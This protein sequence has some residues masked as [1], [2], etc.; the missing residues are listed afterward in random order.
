MYPP[1]DIYTQIASVLMMYYV[2]RV[3]QATPL[4]FNNQE[5]YS[6]WVDSFEMLN[7]RET[8]IEQIKLQLQELS[9]GT[10]YIEEVPTDEIN[11]RFP[12]RPRGPA[13][14]FMMKSKRPDSIVVYFYLSSGSAP[15]Y[16]AN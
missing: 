2:Y 15:I 6:K 7:L 10:L 13:G 4:K 3:P 14:F 9:Y 12:V 5:D 8:A 16:F 1:G 11:A